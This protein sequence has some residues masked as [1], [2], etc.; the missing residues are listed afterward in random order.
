M[1][2]HFAHMISNVYETLHSKT[3]HMIRLQKIWFILI[4]FLHIGKKITWQKGIFMFEF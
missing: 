1:I 2:M 4:F 3:I